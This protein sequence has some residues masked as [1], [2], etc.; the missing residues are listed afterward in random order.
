MRIRDKG[1]AN[2]VGRQ[3]VEIRSK[4]YL[5]L[6][7]GQQLTASFVGTS[8]S[9]VHQFFEQAGTLAI[10]ANPPGHGLDTRLR[11]TTYPPR[12]FVA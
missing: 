12:P 7:R 5:K 3:P 11:S 2:H 9:L 6:F 4:I 8:G 1:A 10:R